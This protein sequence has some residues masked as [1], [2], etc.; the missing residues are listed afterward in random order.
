[1]RRRVKMSDPI[2][3]KLTALHKKHNAFT[4]DFMIQYPKKDEDPK[5]GELRSYFVQRLLPGETLSD[6]PAKHHCVLIVAPYTKR[7]H[8]SVY[9]SKVVADT[10]SRFVKKEVVQYGQ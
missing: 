7:C 9:S 8:I 1:M 2:K 4:I 6:L 10:L 5:V 3:N